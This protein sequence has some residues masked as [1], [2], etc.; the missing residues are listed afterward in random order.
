MSEIEELSD[1]EQIENLGFSSEEADLLLEAGLPPGAVEDWYHDFPSDSAE[2]LIAFF[3]AAP[4]G[5]IEWRKAMFSPEETAEWNSVGFSKSAVFSKVSAA[6][7]EMFESSGLGPTQAA[8]WAE[9]CPLLLPEEI[10]KECSE[11][12]ALDST[13]TPE[14]A[15]AWRHAV[16]PSQLEEWLG[17]GFNPLEV[18]QMGELQV[19]AYDA[20]IWRGQF[21]DDS[22]QVIIDFL[23]RTTFDLDSALAWRVAGADVE[24]AKEWHVY[25][26]DAEGVVWF[27]A[28]FAPQTARMMD[29]LFASRGTDGAFGQ[30]TNKH[31]SMASAWRGVYPDLSVADIGRIEEWIDQ[32]VRDPDEASRWVALGLSAIEA[33]QFAAAGCEDPQ[34]A[35]SWVEIGFSATAVI[36]LF[37]H[38]S[39]EG[40]HSVS[41]FTSLTGRIPQR[42]FK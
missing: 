8:L 9:H 5:A 14:L 16:V 6:Q 4:E 12:R 31:V 2:Q 28:G 17:N 30:E 41:E 27:E 24:I 18:A 25:F 23:G 35:A 13:L 22:P 38:H 10:C 40:W 3:R 39:L 32:G 21:P 20:K 1:L 26:P 11:I 19:Q 33:K 37:E 34:A 29:E 15:L 42:G 36:L 7:A